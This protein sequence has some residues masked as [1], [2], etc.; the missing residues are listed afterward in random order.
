M[1]LLCFFIN[2]KEEREFYYTQSS[3][4]E[5]KIPGPAGDLNVV[6]V[7][8][9]VQKKSEIFPLIMYY[10]GGG[11]T[12]GRPEDGLM[13]RMHKE[14]N[15]VVVGVE[16]SLAPENPYPAGVLDCY[17]ALKYFVENAKEYRIDPNRVIVAGLSAGGLMTTVVTAIATHGFPDDPTA[18]LH[19]PILAQV[20]LQ[21]VLAYP[22]GGYKSYVQFAS[23]GGL[24]ALRMQWFWQMYIQH[25]S[26]CASF[27]CS[28]FLQTKVQLS[29]LPRAIVF[30][31]TADVLRDEARHYAR[32]LKEAGVTTDY[33][34]G[35]GSHMATAVFNRRSYTKVMDLIKEILDQSVKSG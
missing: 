25:P 31:C 10:H 18:K 26:D 22:G 14:A 19:T 8:P 17:S 12:T 28:P 20:A 13:I 30:G 9:K 33:I 21:P 15:A 29:K 7:T 23:V 16:Y 2:T 24:S 27:L 11:M 35:R 4:K 32:I 5:L 34:E 1:D 3:R 6:V